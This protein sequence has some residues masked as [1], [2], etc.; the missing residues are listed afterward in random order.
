MFKTTTPDIGLTIKNAYTMRITNFS[1]LSSLKTIPCAME[2][3]I[4]GKEVNIIGF[5]CPG[6]VGSIIGV[7]EFNT[8]AKKY[9]VPMV[10]SGFEHTEIVYSIYRLCKMIE[11]S[12]F[13]CENT[14]ER[15]VKENGHN[16]AQDLINEIFEKCNSTCRGIGEI[17]GYGL[18]WVCK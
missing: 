3:L 7:E 4:L 1:I 14:Y 10:M 12:T 5:L 9:K 8:L 17:E 16:K 18:R 15:I 11:E 2:G 13:I 6:H